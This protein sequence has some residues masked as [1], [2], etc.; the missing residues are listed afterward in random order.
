ML[1][2]ALLFLALTFSAVAEEAAPPQPSPPAAEALPPR[3]EAT[4]HSFA[5]AHPECVEWSDSCVVCKRAMSV[6][7]STPGIA[8]Q[9]ADIVCRTP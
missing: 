8:C 6:S 1:R 7:C 3:E 4:L 2:T 5:A 9:P